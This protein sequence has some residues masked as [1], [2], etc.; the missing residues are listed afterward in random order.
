MSF[1]L[2]FAVTP[3]VN[4]QKVRVFTLCDCVHFLLAPGVLLF[5]T[6]KLLGFCVPIFAARFLWLCDS[7]LAE[8]I[9]LKDLNFELF[10]AAPGHVTIPFD[11]DTF[12]SEK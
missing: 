12:L 2:N 8:E 10:G 5:R 7:T 3:R 9:V 4:L 6:E 11:H 1:V